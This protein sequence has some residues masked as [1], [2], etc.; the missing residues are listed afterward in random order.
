MASAQF[1]FHSLTWQDSIHLNFIFNSLSIAKHFPVLRV[2][3]C[4]FL[5]LKS[6]VNISFLWVRVVI[7]E[8]YLCPDKR[9]I[10]H[11]QQERWLWRDFRALTSF[12]RN[13]F[14]S[15]YTVWIVRKGWTRWIQLSLQNESVKWISQWTYFHCGVLLL[16]QTEWN[17][18]YIEKVTPHH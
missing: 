17:P 15:K 18:T 10:D 9:Q 8:D 7:S 1:F 6:Q 5:L 11:L 3:W 14:S 13:A 2:G 16:Y 12:V 4:V